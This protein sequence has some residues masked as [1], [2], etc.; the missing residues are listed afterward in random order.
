[1][2]FENIKSSLSILD[3][4]QKKK[5]FIVFILILIGSLFEVTSIYFFYQL[6]QIFIDIDNYIPNKYIEFIFNLFGKESSYIKKILFILLSIYI[7]KFLFFVYNYYKQFNFSNSLTASLS[8]QLIKQYMIKD[9][10]F[11]I[12]KKTSDLVRNI[13][14]E[15]TQF[16]IGVIQQILTLI[17]EFFILISVLIMLLIIAPNIV[18]IS[19]ITIVLIGFVIYKLSKKYFVS[20]GIKRQNLAGE[21]LNI[22]LQSLEGYKELKVYNAINYYLKKFN[23]TAKSFSKVNTMVMLIQQFPRLIFELILIFLIF[24]I[25]LFNFETL[26]NASNNSNFLSKIGL[27][28]LSSFKLIPSISK[29][30]VALQNIK[31]NV[32]SLEILNNEKNTFT[33]QKSDFSKVNFKKKIELKDVSFVYP[34]SKVSILENINLHINKGSKIGIMGESGSGKTTL[35]NLLIGLINP[36]SGQIF[37]DDQKFKIKDNSNWLNKISY[38]PQ[39][40]FMS[41][42][43]VK[44]NIAFGIEDNQID[45]EKMDKSLKYSNLLDLISTIDKGINYNVGKRGDKLSLGQQQRVGIARAFYKNSEI[46]IFDEFTSSLD[47]KTEDLILDIIFKNELKKTMIFISHKEKTLKFCDEIYFVKDKNIKKI[48]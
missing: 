33:S 30:I 25:V 47:D 22:S 15:V 38:V 40:I 14:T 19:L 16:T 29:I 18:F 46:L 24:I 9:Y 43:S 31:F 45:L 2:I 32:P 36:S 5:F 35:V 26:A 41:E 48:K 27:L 28:A 21:M 7:L 10:N 37:I 23:F 11:H 1:M 6:I 8:S 13:N 39:K 12:K 3:K 44:E 17:T 42:T 34:D 20:Y 4:H